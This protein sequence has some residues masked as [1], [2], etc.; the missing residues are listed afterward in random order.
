MK[1]LGGLI[2]C[3]IIYFVVRV[4]LKVIRWRV[5]SEYG[6]ELKKKEEEMMKEIQMKQLKKEKGTSGV[7][8]TAE[9]FIYLIIIVLALYFFLRER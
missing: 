5:K 3:F 6:E 7:T 8:R 2:M 9:L 1:I 4:I